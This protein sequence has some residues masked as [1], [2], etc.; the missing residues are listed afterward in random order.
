MKELVANDG[1]VIKKVKYK[2]TAKDRV[3]IGK[4][5]L[6][7][8]FVQIFIWF[9]LLMA[10]LSIYLIVVKSIK[11]PT[12]DQKWPFE[13]TQIIWRVAVSNYSIALTTISKFI[14]NSFVITLIGTAGQLIVPILTAYAFVRF[15][16]PGKNAIFMGFLALMMI[17]GTLTLTSQYIIVKTLGMVNSI[18]GVILPAVSGAIP[19]SVF[20]LRSFFG[21]V[22]QEMFEAAEIDGARDL[23]VLMRIMVPLSMPIIAVLG[24]QA[25]MGIWNDYLWPSLV[26][27]RSDARTISVALVSLTDQFY[28][29]TH[30]YSVAFAGYLISAI[31]III[32][33]VFCSKQ[34]VEGI[35]AGAFKM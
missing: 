24:V 20:L 11:T 17:P 9:F 34:F 19:M 30:S 5:V 16:F 2:K 14:F 23:T 28:N 3:E 22:S 8:T 4:K 35:S 26:L 29:M 33:F 31:P 32:L 6:S 7:S 27:L 10:W 12:Q 25:F 1:T 18:W 21:G 15:R 13:P